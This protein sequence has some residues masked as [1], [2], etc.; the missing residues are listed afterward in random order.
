MRDPRG[1]GNVL[2][3]DCINVSILVVTDCV[4]L[5]CKLLPWGKVD[6][7]YRRAPRSLL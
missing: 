5:F 3:I 6:E 2:Y 4:P 7:G 1:D